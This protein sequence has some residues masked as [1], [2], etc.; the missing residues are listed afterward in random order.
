[1]SVSQSSGGLILTNEGPA[2][3]RSVYHR[4]TIIGEKDHRLVRVSTFLANLSLILDTLIIPGLGIAIAVSIWVLY[5]SPRDLY[6]AIDPDFICKCNYNGQGQTQQ[7]CECPDYSDGGQ[8][9]KVKTILVYGFMFL[10]DFL[11]GAYM[12]GIGALICIYMV[13]YLL[14]F[15]GYSLVVFCFR[16]C[17]C[18]VPWSIQ[19][20]DKKFRLFMCCNQYQMAKAHQSFIEQGK[21]EAL[22]NT[23][24][25][26]GTEKKKE[27]KGVKFF[28]FE[29]PMVSCSGRWCED[30]WSCE[31]WDQCLV[32]CN[33]KKWV[34]LLWLLTR[35]LAATT[36][37]V[38]L[39]LYP[40]LNC[41]CPLTNN[42]ATLRDKHYDRKWEDL[43]PATRSCAAAYMSLVIMLIVFRWVIICLLRKVTIMP[44]LEVWAFKYLC[45]QPPEAKYLN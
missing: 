13:L 26:G 14:L 23:N 45:V 32:C 29:I 37:I 30:F 20:F 2:L 36:C 4:E 31:L 5:S 8:Y 6:N 7:D 44:K 17:G 38:F 18:Q 28:F 1:M 21:K 15:L 27:K 35:A 42:S 39:A 34:Y 22:C 11:M 41:N 33:G 24:K 43:L 9:T 25:K 12:F 40:E 16:C 19:T 10:P 3:A